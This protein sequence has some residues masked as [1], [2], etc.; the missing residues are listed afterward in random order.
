VGFGLSVAPQNRWEDEDGVRHTSRSSG[1]LC[2]EASRVRVSQFASKLAEERRWVVHVASSWRSYGDE[3]D[4]RR[5]DAMG[6]IKLL[7]PNFVLFFVLGHKGSLVI[8]FLINRTPMAGGEVSIQP[9]LSY[10]LAIVAF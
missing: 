7:Y 1:L 6:C 2:Q 4:D 10:P 3:D 5:V 9:S 8:S